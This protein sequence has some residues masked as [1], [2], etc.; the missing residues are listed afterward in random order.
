MRSRFFE[1]LYLYSLF[2][3][4]F[5]KPLWN[6]AVRKKVT[7]EFLSMA[8][9]NKWSS[10]I[11]F[12]DDKFGIHSIK[13]IKA[14]NKVGFVGPRWMPSLADY[15]FVVKTQH[16]LNPNIVPSQLINATTIGVLKKTLK[17][18]IF[19]NYFLLRGPGCV[20]F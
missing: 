11:Q 19:N 15:I 8:V 9:E 13:Y 1:N 20:V 6:S 4:Y 14:V 16:W 7:I 3:L 12:I 2:I 10:Q 5:L 18:L 17:H